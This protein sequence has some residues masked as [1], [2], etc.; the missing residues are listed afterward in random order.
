MSRY[1][2][3]HSARQAC[4]LT[5]LKYFFNKY[6]TLASYGEASTPEQWIPPVS[7]QMS[8]EERE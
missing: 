7:A 5:I 6:H 8:E 1:R 4:G 3:A 2:Q